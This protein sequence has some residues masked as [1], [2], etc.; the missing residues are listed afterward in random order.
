VETRLELVGEAA[1]EEIALGRYRSTIEA[2][3]SAAIRP[4]DEDADGPSALLPVLH[5]MAGIGT[6]DISPFLTSR[7]S[8]PAIKS[9]LSHAVVDSGWERRV[10]AALDESRRV[11]AWVKNVRLGFTIPHQHQGASH[12]FTPDF[13]C[14]LRGATGAPSDE[15]LIIEVKGLEREQDRSKDVGARR[16]QDA[17]NHWGKL[18]R[19]R[20]AKIHTPYQLSQVLGVADGS[21]GDA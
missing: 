21:K 7:P 2:R 18:G 5:D 1:P 9:H 12:E 13:L 8:L 4:A 10:A 17:V 14:V 15:H 19:W 20:Y 3:V 16:W 11:H 6:T